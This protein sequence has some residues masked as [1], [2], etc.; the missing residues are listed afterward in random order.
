MSINPEVQGLIDIARNWKGTVGELY[1]ALA[2]IYGLPGRYEVDKLFAKRH[3]WFYDRQ[4][5][6]VIMYEHWWDRLRPGVGTAVIEAQE[7]FAKRVPFTVPPIPGFHVKTTDDSL[8]IS[9]PE[10]IAGAFRVNK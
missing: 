1:S 9:L 8:E 5:P 4:F 2:I 6:S 7:R 3:M 10:G